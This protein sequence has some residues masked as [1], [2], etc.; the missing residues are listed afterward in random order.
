MALREVAD[1]YVFANTLVAVKRTGAE[2]A[3]WLEK[4]A[5]QFNQ[6]DPAKAGPQKLLNTSVPTYNFDVISGL[7]YEI[8]L[9][10]PSRY[11]G[12]DPKP[13]P[14]RRIVNLR[15][16]GQPIDP[17]R[18]FVVVTNNYRS[19]GGGGFP[20]LDGSRVVLRAPD[21]NRD[22]I[23]SYLRAMGTL[24]NKPVA[25]WSFAEPLQ[26]VTLAFR[27]AARLEALLDGRSDITRVGLDADG[28]T[29]YQLA[30]G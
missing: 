23:V 25:T 11:Q 4:S 12:N 21:L 22:A 1:L 28:Y 24:R 15:F 3:E 6:I 19:D 20:G 18:E 10:Q 29:E 14:Y 9:T 13:R 8:D 7:T 2:V 27:S 17:A 26:K 16:E 5:G 30:L